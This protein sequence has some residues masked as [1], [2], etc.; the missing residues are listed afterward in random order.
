MMKF[1]HLFGV[2]LFMV[3]L[4]GAPLHAFDATQNSGA[5]TMMEMAD[6]SPCPPADCATMP[7][8]TIALP[9]SVGIFAIPTP[10]LSFML[11]PELTTDVLA[12]TDTTRDAL[13]QVDGLRRPPKI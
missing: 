12:L 4:V 6:G 3:A 1:V 10:E 7:D 5:A 13:S 2:L 9:G 8:C 11:R